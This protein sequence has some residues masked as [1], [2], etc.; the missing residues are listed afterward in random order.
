MPVD[1]RGK[2]KPAKP[3]TKGSPP[4][5]RPKRS[6]PS[7]SSKP[8]P[9]PST[10]P[11]SSAAV[12]ASRT[13]AQSGAASFV[14][15]DRSADTEIGAEV[16]ALG[17]QINGLADDVSLNYHKD[18][19]ADLDSGIAELSA[20]VESIRSRGYV[21][22][23]FL[24]RKLE[25][26]Q[27][28]W[29][30]AR[31][32]LEAELRRQEPAL[33]QLYNQA[34]QEF[35]A[36]AGLG[37]RASSRLAA[38]KAKVD[39]LESRVQ[40]ARGALD[41]VYSNVRDTFYQTRSQVGEVTWLLDALDESPWELLTNESPIQAVEAH[42]WRDGKKEGPEG[43]LYI[44]DQ[45]LLFEQKEKV[46]T[47]KVL[48][49]TTESE[50]VQEL[51]MTVPLTGIESCTAS[52]SG[53]GGHQD[54]LDFSF[55]EG[56]FVNAHFHVKGQDSDNWAVLVKRVLNGDIQRERYYPEGVDADAVAAAEEAALANAPAVCESCGAPLDP[57]IVR[58]QRSIQCE[59]CGTVMRW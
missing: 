30:D 48:F 49:V 45:R 16:A 56:D 8:K 13:T 31:P 40:S 41:A 21:Y 59:Y 25:T 20:D 14:P 54:H 38:V 34:A 46:A 12:P 10:R 23:N 35:N 5:P 32:R 19:M 36:A 6:A 58:G 37:A 3:V 26:I 11:A 27:Q 52:H 47:K 15:L 2:K 53:L 17:D 50:M 22:K 28:K 51:L 33:S 4:A 42:W 9:R 7:T 55:N 39:N 29:D 1:P 44:S 43:I 24:E 57:E 18:A